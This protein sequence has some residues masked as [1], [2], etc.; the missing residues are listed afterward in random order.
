MQW[1]Y[2][3]HTI[4]ST[5]KQQAEGLLEVRRHSSPCPSHQYGVLGPVLAK[6]PSPF[7]SS[8]LLRSLEEL[9]P[10][11]TYVSPCTGASRMTQA[12]LPAPLTMSLESIGAFVTA[13]AGREL[14]SPVQPDLR[15]ALRV[16]QESHKQRQSRCYPQKNGLKVVFG[17][18]IPN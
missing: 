4:Y 3:G 11:L 6:S 17:V 9:L 10:A 2:V 12:F 18:F 5:G 1:S 7:P 15:I 8:L 14:A 16:K 13:C